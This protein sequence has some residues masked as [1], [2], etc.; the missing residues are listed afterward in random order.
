M[1]TNLICMHT[2]AFLFR[3]MQFKDS[4]VQ[5]VMFNVCFFIYHVAQLGCC[6]SV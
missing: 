5:L 3:N 6:A 4:S 1:L 2:L